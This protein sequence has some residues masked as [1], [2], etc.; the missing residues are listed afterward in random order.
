MVAAGAAE[1]CL[2]F[3]LPAQRVRN[4]LASRHTRRGVNSPRKHGKLTMSGADHI[5]FYNR[6][7]FCSWL[8]C[9]KS[10]PLESAC[11]LLLRISTARICFLD[12]RSISSERED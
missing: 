10:V 1:D 7:C 6:V 2:P 4:V 8:S 12:L 11:F 5:F 3:G 9:L